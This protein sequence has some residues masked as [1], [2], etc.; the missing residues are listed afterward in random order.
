MSGTFLILTLLVSIVCGWLS[1]NYLSN[2]DAFDFSFHGSGNWTDGIG[3]GMEILLRLFLIGV[4][5][6]ATTLIVSF[7]SFAIGFF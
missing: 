2:G 7:I 1:G 6:V 5:Y 3:E 4:V